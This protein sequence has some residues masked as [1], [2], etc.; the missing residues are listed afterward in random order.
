L[1]NVQAAPGLRHSNLVVDPLL[2]TLDWAATRRRF[3][4]RHRSVIPQVTAAKKEV[5]M[6]FRRNLRQP[7]AFAN[8]YEALPDKVDKQLAVYLLAAFQEGG[9][10]KRWWRRGGRRSL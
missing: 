8:F 6:R 1:I 5:V 7:Q 9:E 4:F 2:A 10:F 3:Q